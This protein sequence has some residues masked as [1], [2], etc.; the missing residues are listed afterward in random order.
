MNQLGLHFVDIKE[1]DVLFDAPTHDENI[2]R[3]KKAWP[4]AAKIICAKCHK[5]DWLGRVKKFMTM[6]C[7]G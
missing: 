6:K 5:H 2:A 1:P 3:L 7:T 4:Y